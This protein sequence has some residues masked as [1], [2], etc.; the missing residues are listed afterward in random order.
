MSSARDRTSRTSSR[1][2]SSHL[3]L[4][5]S[6]SK[7]AFAVNGP[8]DSQSR[9][10]RQRERGATGGRGGA[11]EFR[12]RST[13]ND[14]YIGQSHTSTAGASKQSSTARARNRAGSA[15][16]A[17]SVSDVASDVSS[18]AHHGEWCELAGA[19]SRVRRLRASTRAD[20]PAAAPVYQ[21]SGVPVTEERSSPREAR[22]IQETSDHQVSVGNV[23]SR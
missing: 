20:A 5:T 4:P 19:A 15:T 3:F 18:A 11:A 23:K 14:P 1:C 8:D 9:W 13:R 17:V 6:A 10:P 21:A 12:V 16:W 2:Q 7:A 22:L